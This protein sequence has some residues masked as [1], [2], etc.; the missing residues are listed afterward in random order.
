MK[1]AVLFVFLV[2]SLAAA[3]Q[4]PEQLTQQLFQ[5]PPTQQE[6]SNFVPDV[7]LF[8]SA[9]FYVPAGYYIDVSLKAVNTGRSSV[10]SVMIDLGSANSTILVDGPTQR[11]LGSLKPGEEKTL[12]YSLYSS[13]ETAPGTYYMPIKV[14]YLR[15]NRPFSY[16]TGVGVSVFSPQPVFSIEVLDRPLEVGIGGNITVNIKNAGS[17]PAYNAYA[18]IRRA[19]TAQQ[20]NPSSVDVTQLLSGTAPAGTSAVQDNSMV[21]GS[22]AVFLGDIKP[23]EQKSVNY[24]I[25][26][27]ADL[28]PRTYAY[29][30]QISFY[31]QSANQSI[32]FSYPFGMLFVGRPSI[33]LSSIEVSGSGGMV[34]IS[35]DANNVGSEKVKSVILEATE[36]DLFAPAY[37][38]FSYYVG[39]MEPDDFIPFEL[40]VMNKEPN[41]EPHA[42]N[43]TIRYLDSRNKEKI[44]LFTITIPPQPTEVESNRG[45]SVF[46]LI[47][48]LLA[49]IIIA[50][51]LFISVRRRKRNE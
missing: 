39:T 45:P 44:E 40:K 17:Y 47:L 21:V 46:H 16:T 28:A 32:A 26:P 10:E 42:Y 2:L 48:V 24:T 33:Y 41:T 11:S 29:E 38:G 51:V 14:S 50:V 43:I 1:S 25:V 34:T 13:Y 36:D 27:D 35:G 12:G 3:Q 37:S 6:G 18:T 22:A 5:L 23:G 49:I 15:H 31:P 19:Q 8:T 20:Q 4:V 9:P 7:V 30:M